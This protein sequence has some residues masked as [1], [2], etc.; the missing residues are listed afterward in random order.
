MTLFEKTVQLLKETKKTQKQ[1]AEETGL[2]Y[3]WITTLSQGKVQDA[4]VN[5]VQRLYEYLSRKKLKV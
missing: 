2:G 1:I 4:S 5:K 3:W